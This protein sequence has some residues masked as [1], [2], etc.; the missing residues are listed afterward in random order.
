MNSLILLPWIIV[1]EVIICEAGD[2]I[3]SQ[4]EQFDVELNRCEWTNLPIKMQRMYLIFLSYTQ[5]PKNIQCY[6]GMSCSRE[7]FK[8]VFHLKKIYRE[9]Y[10]LRI[11]FSIVIFNYRLQLRDFHTS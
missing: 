2:R 5:K 4:F 7:S 3:T 11:N 9:I 10:K 8:R 1:L 6:G